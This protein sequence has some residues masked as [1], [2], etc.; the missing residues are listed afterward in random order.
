M[1]AGPKIIPLRSESSSTSWRRRVIAEDP[2]RGWLP[3]LRAS[4]IFV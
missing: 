1:G 2:V 4:D 3:S